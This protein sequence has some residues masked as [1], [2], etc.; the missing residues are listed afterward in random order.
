MTDRRRG[1]ARQVR[2]IASKLRSR[3]KLAGEQRSEVIGRV[4][5]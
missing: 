2:Q 5:R 1:A 3:A 4:T